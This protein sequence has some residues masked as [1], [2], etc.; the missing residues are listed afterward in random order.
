MLASQIVRPLI[1]KPAVDCKRCKH[2][3]TIN[4][5]MKPKEAEIN[6]LYEDPGLVFIL[7]IINGFRSV[8][9]TRYHCVKH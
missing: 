4:R 1:V 8:P 9:A 2:Q 7:Q 6:P 5:P 3:Y